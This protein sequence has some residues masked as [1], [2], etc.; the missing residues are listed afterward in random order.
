M[1]KK[2]EQELIAEGIHVLMG[3]GSMDFW[4][5][6]RNQSYRA[7]TKM[8]ESEPDKEKLNAK[9]LKMLDS[10]FHH[11]KKAEEYRLK[12][13]SLDL[14]DPTFD[15]VD[16]KRIFHQTIATKLKGATD[17]IHHHLLHTSPETGKRKQSVS[18]AQHWGMFDGD[19]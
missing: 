8:A 7:G 2:T 1:T 19:E 13:N 9:K 5:R 12:A 4:D 17:A 18:P 3:E 16:E 11:D 14:K 15:G 10:Y 6:L